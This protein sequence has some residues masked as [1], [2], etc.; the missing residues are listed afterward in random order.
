MGGA[1]SAKTNLW[2]CVPGSS[3]WFSTVSFTY[4]T[5][6]QVVSLPSN[7]LIN[8]SFLLQS[9]PNLIRPSCINSSN[10]LSGSDCPPTGCFWSQEFCCRFCSS[11]SALTRPQLLW[12]IL[13]HLFPC[14]T[15]LIAF[16]EKSLFQVTP[17]RRESSKSLN[18]TLFLFPSAAE[19]Q[20]WPL[21]KKKT[22][23]RFSSPAAQRSF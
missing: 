11:H 3:L 21:K 1:S 18:I 22:K 16:S 6:L 17:D 9:V 14:A 20:K 12:N 8:F 10:Q 7:K 4:I 13:L 23:N 19:S 15:E 5:A 2:R